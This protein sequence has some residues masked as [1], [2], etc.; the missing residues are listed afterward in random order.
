MGG[1]H[2]EGVLWTFQDAESEEGDVV[3]VHDV[4]PD[5]P[6]QGLVGSGDGSRATEDVGRDGVGPSQGTRDRMDADLPA[7]DAGRRELLPL[8]AVRGGGKLDVHLVA[9]GGEGFCQVLHMHGV[10]AEVVGRVERRRHQESERFH[11][12]PSGC[13]SSRARSSSSGPASRTATRAGSRP[14]WRGRIAGSATT[15]S[16]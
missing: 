4:G 1:V 12:F 14:D 6:Q 13:L 7:I 9:T 8:Q 16:G 10:P 3:E 11:G 15:T 2:H 5:V